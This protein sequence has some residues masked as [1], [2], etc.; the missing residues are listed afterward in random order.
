MNE[1]AACEEE[2]VPH[3]EVKMA[4]LG[5]VSVGKTTVLNA[6]LQDYYSEVSRR[7]LRR[8]ICDRNMLERIGVGRG[9]GCSIRQRHYQQYPPRSKEGGLRKH[10]EIDSLE[11]WGVGGEEVVNE[12]LGARSRARE[13]RDATIRKSRKVDR[14]SFLDDFRSGLIDSKAFKYREEIQGRADVDVEERAKINRP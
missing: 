12:A 9:G 10:F 13:I 5:H 11:V 1:D 7:L 8:D 14:A 3:F 6:L 2:L 4:L